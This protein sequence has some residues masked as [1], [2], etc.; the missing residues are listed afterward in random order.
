MDTLA[1]G[2][3]SGNFTTV[4]RVSET[5]DGSVT[6]NLTNVSILM[7]DIDGPRL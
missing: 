4:E 5:E 7:E 2:R 6:A 1:L 3:C